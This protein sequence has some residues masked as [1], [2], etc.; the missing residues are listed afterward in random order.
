MHLGYKLISCPRFYQAVLQ[1]LQHNYR[2]MQ[3][4]QQQLRQQQQ[5]RQTVTPP[6]GNPG[7]RTPGTA[8]FNAFQG[9]SVPKN[10]P[11]QVRNA[12]FD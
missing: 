6:S 7:N 12:T 8:G 4:H 1:Q 11:Q 9:S 10:Y 2:M 5:Q 3:Q